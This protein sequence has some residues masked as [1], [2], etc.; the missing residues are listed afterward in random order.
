[1]TRICLLTL[2]SIL[3]CLLPALNAQDKYGEIIKADGPVGWWRFEKLEG[4]VVANEMSEELSARTHG[5]LK[6][7]QAGPRPSDYPDFSPTNYA[8]RIDSGK[9]YFVVKDP[10]DESVLDFKV[11]DGITLEAW[12]KIDSAL[13]GA[14][15]YIIGKGRTH[16]PG[17]NH[18]NQSYSLRLATAGGKSALSFF[19]VDESGATKSITDAGHRWTS[20]KSVPEDGYWHHVAVTYTFGDDK[21]MRGYIDGKPVKGKWD[22]SGATAAAPITDNDELWIGSSMGGLATLGASLDEVA[23]YR[24]TLSLKE[25][26]KHA[27]VDIKIELFTFDEVKD[28]PTDHVRVEIFEKISAAR[29]WTFRAGELE[30]LF[31][32]GLTSTTTKA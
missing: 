22:L 7:Q 14:Y 6:M 30:P 16:N 24:K 8:V 19:F 18:N 3:C 13:R 11:G 10:G 4:G 26:K 2:F 29:K 27:N 32:T 25:I 9:N 21:S 31:E 1:M 17:T 23:I 20:N 15:P 28:A 12:V 5:N